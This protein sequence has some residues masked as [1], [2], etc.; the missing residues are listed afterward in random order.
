[1]VRLTGVF[2][3]IASK[4]ILVIG[5]LLLDTYTIGKTRRISPEAPVAVVNVVREEHRPGGSGNVILNLISLGSQVVALGRVG[6]DEAGRNLYNALKN[7]QVDVK[8]IFTEDSFPTPV[9]NRVLAENQ[10]IVR[11]DYETI[12]A[13]TKEVEDK[14]IQALPSLLDGVSIVAISDYGKGFLS[15]RILEALISLS[16]QKNIPVIAD[17]KGVDF[18]KYN[19]ATVIKPNLG[20][21]YAAANLPLDTPI[22]QVAERILKNINA[23]TLMITRGDAGISLFHREGTH[24]TF[25]V[26][27]RE[28]KDVT[29]AGDTV[30]AMLACAL[31]NQLPLATAVQLSN[32]AA[33]IAIE[34]FGCARITLS[35]LARRLLEEDLANKVF[36]QEHLFALR[37]ALRDR[38]FTLLSMHESEGLS[39]PL[40]QALKKLKT[41]DQE[42]LLHIRGENPNPELISLFS[43]L[44]NVDFIIL[45]NDSLKSLC[46]EIAP[47]EIYTMQ[48]GISTQ[49]SS[50]QEI[51]K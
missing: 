11:V 10:Q 41:K 31:A 9:K 45:S 19:G 13:V 16:Q 37:E 15:K 27:V 23:K 4:K 33:G 12:V 21:A 26:K 50:F 29:G 17:P 32:V 14:I 24:E 3:Q 8:G 30:L 43:S 40:F 35:H 6:N 47:S 36:D 22:E 38:N 34:H 42:L 46:H 25:E 20:E 18:T 39:F 44:H 28:V 7:E 2:S 51:F 49:V 48:Y 5:D 1:M